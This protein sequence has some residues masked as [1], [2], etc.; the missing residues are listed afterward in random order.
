MPGRLGRGLA[1]ALQG[2]G[3]SLKLDAAAGRSI[4]ARL[5]ARGRVAAWYPV[6]CAL[7]VCLVAL[8]KP[9]SASLP[10]PALAAPRRTTWT[11][12]RRSGSWCTA[13]SSLR[14]GRQC[15]ER[16]G[17]APWGPAR[18]AATR[19]RVRRAGP[20]PTRA[21][22]SRVPRLPSPLPPNFRPRPEN[23]RPCTGCLNCRR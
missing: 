16:A 7:L 23:F 1:A 21:S 15:F 17:S 9:H 12:A 3:C 13:A 14:C 10:C 5:W 20:C 2:G 8:P 4:A 18:G 11:W 6:L 19:L 22:C